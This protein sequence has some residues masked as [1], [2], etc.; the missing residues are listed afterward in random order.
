MLDCTQLRIPTS[1]PGAV[2]CFVMIRSISSCA[3]GM[4]PAGCGGSASSTAGGIVNRPAASGTV[5]TNSV[6]G[7]F[8]ISSLFT[9]CPNRATVEVCKSAVANW[10]QFKTQSGSWMKPLA[11]LIALTLWWTE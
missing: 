9:A 3:W 10:T 6:V 8:E 4:A 7:Q 5:Q 11:E 2:N 1:T